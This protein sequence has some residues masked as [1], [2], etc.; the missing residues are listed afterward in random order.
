MLYCHYI[1]GDLV[2]VR[3]ETRKNGVSPKLQSDWDG[4]QVVS[5]KLGPFIYE[6]TGRKRSVIV[7]HDRLKS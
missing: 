7:H 6:V 2:F 5:K 4:P 1:D 3:N